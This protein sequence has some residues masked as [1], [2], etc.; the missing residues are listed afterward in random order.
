MFY[1]SFVESFSLL[2]KYHLYSEYNKSI[3]LISLSEASICGVR[4]KCPIGC[5]EVWMG[6]WACLNMPLCVFIWEFEGDCV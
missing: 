3:N 5:V 4:W 2:F 1:K 6:V